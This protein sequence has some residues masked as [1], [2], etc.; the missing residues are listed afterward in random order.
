MELTEVMSLW[1]L[2]LGFIT[3]VVVLAKMH[4]EIETLREKVKSLFDLWNKRS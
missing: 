3:L 2:F 1:P 4:A